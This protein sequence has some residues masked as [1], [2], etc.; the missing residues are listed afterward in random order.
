MARQRA[1]DVLQALPSGRQMA[2]IAAGRQP[3]VV[4][5]YT[6]EKALLRQSISQMQVTDA[7][8]HMREAILLA[9]SFTQ[10]R[11]TQEVVVIGDGAYQHLD[12][13]ELPRSQ[14]R[15]IQVTW[16]PAQCR[17]YPAWAF[18]KVMAYLAPL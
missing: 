12:D 14:V 6:D 16:W 4:T 8:G 3:Q 17:H 18:R 5:F 15:H 1:L 13:L 11:L 7:P 9:L 10:G 2:V